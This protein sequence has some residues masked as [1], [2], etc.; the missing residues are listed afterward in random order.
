MNQDF[1]DYEIILVDDGSTDNSGIICDEYALK[2]TNITVI[3][4]QNGGLSDAR[5]A[6]IPLAKGEYILF[7]D[8]D[9]YIENGSMSAIVDCLKEQKETTDV[10]FLNASKVFP[11]GEK[12]PLGDNYDKSKINGRSKDEVLKH[13]AFLP[14]Y[15]GSAC[16]KLIRKSVIVN[17]GIFF[18]KG[19]YSEDIDWTIKLLVSSERFTYCDAKYYCYR[20]N[21]QGSIT[22]STTVKHVESLLHIIEKWTSRDMVRENQAEI[23]AFLAYEYMI[24]LFLYNSLS[25]DDKN[26]VKSKIKEYSWL[27]KYGKNFKIKITRM[28]FTL[29]GIEITSRLLG[30]VR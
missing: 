25:K 18:E 8:S 3:H 10:I 11:D 22:N 21:R 29:T 12:V 16:T 14:K 19:I 20:Q 1:K 27:L 6:G 30:L 24:M 17:N 7:I 5:N 4:K 9:D 2:Y 15:P 13:I 26:K 28:A 23:N